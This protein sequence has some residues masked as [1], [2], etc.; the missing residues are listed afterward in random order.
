M[1]GHDMLDLDEWAE[2]R[3][4]LLRLHAD[5]TEEVKGLVQEMMANFRPELMGAAE[6]KSRAGQEAMAAIEGMWQLEEECGLLE[7]KF[8]G[9]VGCGWDELDIENVDV[10]FIEDLMLRAKPM[11]AS[12]SCVRGRQMARLEAVKAAYWETVSGLEPLAVPRPGPAEGPNPAA[13]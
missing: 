11:N 5:I 10:D 2:V 1:A 9:F 8:Q 13:A 4:K 12:L 7:E 3:D 6:K